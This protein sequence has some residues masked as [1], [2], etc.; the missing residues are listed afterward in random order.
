MDGSQLPQPQPRWKNSGSFFPWQWAQG[1]SDGNI[2]GCRQ[3]Q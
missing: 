3:L 2:L 1:K